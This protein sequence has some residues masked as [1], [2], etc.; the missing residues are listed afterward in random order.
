MP[1]RLDQHLE[2]RL[3][4]LA[5]DDRLRLA[6]AIDAGAIVLCSNDYLGYAR[7]PLTASALAG[8]SGASRLISGD[9]DAHRRAEAALA[10]WLGYDA[11]LLFSSGYAANV[12]VLAALAQPGDV[13]VSDRLNHASIIDG[14]RLSRATVVVVPHRDAGAA[15]AA[16][17]GARHAPRRWLVTESYFSMDGDSPDLAAL[18]RAADE[19]DAALIVDEAHAL[20]VFGARGAGLS[21][22][23]GVRPD[24]VVGTLGKAVGLAGAFVA[25][26]TT[27]RS[28]L[29]NS[30]RSF[31]FSTAPP[32]QLAGAIA[33]RVERIQADDAARARLFDLV[34]GARAALAAASVAIAP[35]HGPIIPWVV[36]DARR[37]LEMSRAL[38]QRGVFV[39]AIRPPTV[40]AG[41]A[42]LRITLHA[43]LSDADLDRSLDA[44]TALV[45]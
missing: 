45:R 29:W 8:G 17:A 35:S 41:M 23:L 19:H 4:Q 44:L 34:R 6:P 33:A 22:S 5:A 11:A 26:S 31:V 14:C 21:A 25:G 32:P 16:L 7:E 12:G 10:A 2:E 39:A 38:A 27:L 42:R 1:T 30:A 15:A 18:R 28:W 24:V 9:H 13:V 3:A 43:R 37:A 36:G 20:G 40:P